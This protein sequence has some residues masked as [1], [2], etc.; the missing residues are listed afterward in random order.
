MP[1]RAPLRALPT[2]QVT[3]AD[4]FRLLGANQGTACTL[5]S[6][7]VNTMGAT[8]NFTG[9][10]TN[11]SGGVV[12]QTIDTPSPEPQIVVSAEL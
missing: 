4:Q 12:V 5:T 3:G 6:F 10:F 7:N 1:F 11:P 8:C 9:T 2:V